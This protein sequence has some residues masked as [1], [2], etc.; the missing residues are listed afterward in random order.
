MSLYQDLISLEIKI[1]EQSD[2]A[3][4]AIVNKSHEV[5]LEIL[6]ISQLDK[7]AFLKPNLLPGE[8]NLP[9]HSSMQS[10]HSHPFLL[11]RI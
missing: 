6:A 7:K 4:H 8:N 3:F 5:G 11:G 10:A 9:L 2:S 1:K